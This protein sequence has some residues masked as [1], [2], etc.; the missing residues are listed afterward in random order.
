MMLTTFESI[1]KQFGYCIM[2]QNFIWENKIQREQKD[3][4]LL[5]LQGSSIF[6]TFSVTIEYIKQ[7]DKMSTFGL[8][9]FI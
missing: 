3:F 5:A 6:S 9:C 2:K 7:K 4:F 8:V 1:P